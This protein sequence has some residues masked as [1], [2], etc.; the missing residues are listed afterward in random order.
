MLK[1]IKIAVDIRDLRIAKT[2]S[3]TY[4]EEICREFKKNHP[5]FT[6]H[7]ID[8]WLPVYTG[9]NKLLKAI[10]HI[11]FF[12]WKQLLLPVICLV[13]RYDILFC[14]DYF[15]PLLKLKVKTVVVSMTCPTCIKP[16]CCV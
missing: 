10:E 12:T 8:T 4:L 14:T 5:G 11:R 2:G 16:N 6:F 1:Q 7:F 9:S 3:K 15:V 13:N